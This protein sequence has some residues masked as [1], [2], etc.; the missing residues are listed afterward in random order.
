MST[1]RTRPRV[2]PSAALACCVALSSSGVRAG[3][4][5]PSGTLD[6][7]TSD[8]RGAIFIDNHEAGE[9]SFHGALVVGEH[10]VSVE[11]AGFR[12]F[13]KRVVIDAGKGASLAVTL[14]REEAA[15]APPAPSPVLGGPYGGF[16][17]G[18]S[19]EPTGSGSTF[20]QTCPLTG[21]VSCSASPPVGL[22]LG[23]YVGYTWD[24]IGLELFGAFGL[25]YTSPSS[26]FD[27]VVQPG[28]NA[29]LTGPARTE[30]FQILRVGGMA[31][32]RARATIDGKK[33]RVSFALG[34]GLGVHGMLMERTATTTGSPSASDTFVPQPITYVTPALSLEVAVA[35]RLTSSVSLTAGLSTWLENAGT[36]ATTTAD[37]RHYLFPLAVPLRTPSYRLASGTQFFLWPVVGLQFGP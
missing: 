35:Y 29:A 37:P 17:L 27:G 34:P 13:V 10:E 33:L 6:V 30:Q 19:F 22:T 4:E 25:D 11:R 21:A 28:S 9:G 15:P 8:G 24:P 14:A 32:L 26:T 18:P 7:T 1:H 12:R 23:G 2:V 5:A 36:D 16:F 3:D 20:E 31:A